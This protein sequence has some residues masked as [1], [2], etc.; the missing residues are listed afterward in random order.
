MKANIP[1]KL[2]RKVGHLTMARRV[3]EQFI[4]TISRGKKTK[5]FV[6]LE[7]LLELAHQDEVR[8]ISTQILQFPTDENNQTAIVHALVVTSKG[9]FEGTGDANPLNTNSMIAPHNI[10]MAETRAVARAL[11][12]ATNVGMTAWEELGQVENVPEQ[13]PTRE[14]APPPATESFTPL[15]GHPATE[16]QMKAIYSIGNRI[17]LS[18]DQL[19]EYAIEV[20]KRSTED[21]NRTQASVMIKHLLN[22][23]KEG[24]PV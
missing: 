3:P 9:E 15:N 7:G 2:K 1:K 18:R 24:Q 11:R 13:E 22:L 8:K 19:D 20:F 23:Q 16:A 6:L 10:R 4:I 17:N 14:F 12:F 21:I 5:E